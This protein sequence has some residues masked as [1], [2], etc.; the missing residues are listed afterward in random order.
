MAREKKNE[1]RC[2]VVMLVDGECVEWSKSRGYVPDRH[3]VEAYVLNVL[4]ARHARVEVVPFDPGMVATL[5]ALKRLKPALVFN[6]T[7]WVE[8]DRRLD[9][10]IAGLLDILKLTYTGTGPEGMRLARDKALSKQIVAGLGVAVP[11]YFVADAQGP[12]RN[13]GLPY[14]LV[15]KPQFGDGSDEVG[16]GS[17]VRNDRELAARVRVLRKRFHEPLIC[18]EYVPGR[19]LYVALL[20]SRPEVMRPVE[21]VIGRK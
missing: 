5:D 18:E 10:A 15:V 13:P 12:V 17:L 1:S 4:R 20:G 11:R 19:D 21:L 9:A 6:L 14:P 8:S 7:E 3:S 2:D 16:A